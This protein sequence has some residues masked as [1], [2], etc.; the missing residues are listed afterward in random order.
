MPFA[1]GRLNPGVSI[2]A[3]YLGRVGEPVAC[4]LEPVV[5]LL[6]PPGGT[7]IVFAPRSPGWLK[8]GLFLGHFGL[9]SRTIV[10]SNETVHDSYI[11][12]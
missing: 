10:V 5:D 7:L 4:L 9:S 11:L 8:F 6:S 1:Q 2:G 12:F 3:N